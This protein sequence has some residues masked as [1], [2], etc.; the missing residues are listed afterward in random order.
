MSSP[1]A[2]INAIQQGKHSIR[3]DPSRESDYNAFLTNKAFS[4]HYDTVIQS[5]EMNQNYGLD[6]MLQY[7]YYLGTI[8][9]CKRPHR[10]YKSPKTDKNVIIVAEHYKINKKRAL[11]YLSLMTDDDLIKIK[12]RGGKDE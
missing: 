10:W 8:R 9:K 6:S 5:N 2:F 1:F 4:F 12:N 11:E 7:D 3:S